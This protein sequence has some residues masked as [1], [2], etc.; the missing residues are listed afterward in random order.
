L[1][2]FRESGERSFLDDFVGWYDWISTGD[3]RDPSSGEDEGGGSDERPSDATGAC[4]HREI[5]SN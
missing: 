1:E 4:R 2:E 5:Y 3:E